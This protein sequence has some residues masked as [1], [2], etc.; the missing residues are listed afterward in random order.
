[1]AG[2]T[3][4]RE[5]RDRIYAD[6]AANEAWCAAQPETRSPVLVTCAHRD[7]ATRQKCRN[8]S[9]VYRVTVPESKINWVH[10]YVHNTR[11]T[12]RFE[13]ADGNTVQAQLGCH[14]A[15]VLSDVA[16]TYN[17]DKACDARCMNARGPSCDCRCGGE[18]HGRSWG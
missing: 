18:L 3:L 12:V 10:G 1:M 11:R 5:D 2:V 16:G 6:A 4:T 15:N 17:E 8:I 7:R 9:R 14:G 13:D